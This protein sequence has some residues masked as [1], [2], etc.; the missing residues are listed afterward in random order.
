VNRSDLFLI[1]IALSTIHHDVS[2]LR[3]LESGWR[4]LGDT[5]FFLLLM[6]RAVWHLWRPDR[7]K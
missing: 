6:G 3:D 7:E 4:T 1:F 5:V 2:M